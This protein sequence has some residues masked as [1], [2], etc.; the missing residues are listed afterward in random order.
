MHWITAQTSAPVR[1]CT[2]PAPC[3]TA[4]RCPIQCGTCTYLPIS[5]W[6]SYRQNPEYSCPS[7]PWQDTISA[8]RKTIHTLDGYTSTTA[9]HTRQSSKTS[10]REE[11]HMAEQQ[12]VIV[13]A[14]R[15]PTG[16]F[17]GSLAHLS[18]PELGAI[19]IKAA[20]QR[21]GI[22]PSAIDEVV[23]GNVVTAGIGQA[24]ARQAAIKAGLSVDIPAF[25]V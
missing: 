6:A 7:Q 5:A 23:M 8:E 9:W 2:P 22:D 11:N 17:L 20:L 14:A 21:S 1:Q 15:T 4:R 19:A 24:P 10:G 12:A 13:G 3:C 25:T 16:K 18:A